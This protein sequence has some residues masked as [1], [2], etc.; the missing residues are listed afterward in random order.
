MALLLGAVADDYTGASDLANTLNR[1]GLSTIQ[2]IGVPAPGLEVDDAEAIVVALKI[3]SVE[4][5][6]AVEAATA[7]YDWL[8][9]RGAKHVMY[10]VCSTFELDR[11][12]QY[13]AGGGRSWRES[14]WRL[15]SGDTSLSG[16]R[17]HRLSRPFV[18]WLDALERKPAE[19]PPAQSDARFQ[20]RARVAAA[21][22]RI[23]RV[24]RPHDRRTRQRGGLARP[25]RAVRARL[26]D[27]DR[28]RRVRA[29][30]RSARRRGGGERVLCRRL[31]SGPWTCARS[32]ARPQRYVAREHA[33]SRR[34]PRRDPGGVLLSG[35]AGTDRGGR[36]RNSCAPAF[37]AK[38]D[39]G[40]WRDRTRARLGERAH[41][42]LAPSSS[43]RAKSPNR[44]RLCKRAT[45]ETSLAMR[46][47]A[48]SPKSPQ[49]SSTW[50]CGVS[51]SRAARRRAPRSTG[52]AFRRSVSG[53]KSRRGCR[54]CARS[55]ERAATCRWRSSPATLADG[56]SSLALCP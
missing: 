30:S 2:T 53:R 3:R 28:R 49:A 23:R 55:G 41:R 39:R 36:E 42:G 5:S 37:H 33:R 17:P 16:N 46:S 6:Q 12:G 22:E 56:I 38:A 31:G 11:R 9:A 21:I 8:N 43:P 25:R 50:A 40:F 45:A 10:K 14:A 35:H 27:G 48:R 7:A 44:S 32:C 24:H 15:R 51:R 54:S 13:R 20:S 47:K 1:N 29:R 52:W 19:R 4:A 26:C 34:R 18:R